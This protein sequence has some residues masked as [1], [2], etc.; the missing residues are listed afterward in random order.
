[1]TAATPPIAAG[2]SSTRT[3]IGSTVTPA[4]GSPPPSRP[5]LRLGPARAHPPRRRRVPPPETRHRRH[6]HPGPGLPVL[7][8]DV[9]LLRVQPRVLRGVEVLARVGGP[10]S[11]GRNHELG[12]RLG[13]SLAI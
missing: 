9:D 5:S 2:F 6:G 13:V 8:Y 1:M 10:V 3:S 12:Q 4:A 11:E 7:L